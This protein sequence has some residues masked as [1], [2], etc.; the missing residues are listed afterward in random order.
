MRSIIGL[1]ILTTVV[2]TSGSVLLSNKINPLSQYWN[3]QFNN[4][5]SSGFRSWKKISD[6]SSY[7]AWVQTKTNPFKILAVDSAQDLQ[8]ALAKYALG[9]LENKEGLS[10]NDWLEKYS[11]D[12]PNY[13]SSMQTVMIKGYRGYQYRYRGNQQAMD[14]QT[15]IYIPL[16]DKIY[17]FA[18]FVLE[19]KVEDYEPAL[20]ELINRTNFG[21]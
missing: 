16:N 13:L 17:S 8:G 12:E 15:N 19:G 6:T 14:N 2:G 5:A 11:S 9:I 18:V 7:Q 20:M 10:V 1:L 3:D 21:G 4:N